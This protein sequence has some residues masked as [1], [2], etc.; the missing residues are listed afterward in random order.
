MAICGIGV[1]TW[2]L[3]FIF[4]FGICAGYGWK[5]RKRM[6]KSKE[7]LVIQTDLNIRT[8]KLELL[9]QKVKRDIKEGVVVLPYWA[10]AVI[11]PKDIKIITM[12]DDLK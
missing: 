5:V 7:A 2:L 1:K 8:E 11:V 6:N 12:E 9:R 4:C 10:R 3:N